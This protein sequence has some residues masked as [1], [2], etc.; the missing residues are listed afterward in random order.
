MLAA[1]ARQQ[2]FLLQSGVVA[3]EKRLHGTRRQR[4]AEY[5]EC[6]GVQASQHEKQLTFSLH[7]SWGKSSFTMFPSWKPSESS[8]QKKPFSQYF[9]ISHSTPVSS[10]IFLMLASLLVIASWLS[11]ACAGKR[12]AFTPQVQYCASDDGEFGLTI[13]MTSKNWRQVPAQGIKLNKKSPL[14][15]KSTQHRQSS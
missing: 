12:Q 8:M 14:A 13:I 1:S 4:C 5:R 15:S 6:A 10:A 11:V 2:I 7:N 3:S 9:R